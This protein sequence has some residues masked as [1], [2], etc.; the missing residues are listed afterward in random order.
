MITIGNC[1]LSPPRNGNG[2]G[3][4]LLYWFIV[5]A[6]TNDHTLSVLKQ[7]K[8]IT[9]SSGCQR[10]KISFTGLKQGAS[11]VAFL[12]G[13]L[14]GK[15]LSFPFPAYRGQLHYAWPSDFCSHHDSFFLT[16][17]LP[18]FASLITWG[19]TG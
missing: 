14:G 3:E 12:L 6:V 13:A 4:W 18:S 11:R 7:H 9:Y 15:S 17:L 1:L 10:S 19:P 8:C 16:L 2:G 5:A